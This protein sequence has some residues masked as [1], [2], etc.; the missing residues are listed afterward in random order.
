MERLP[1]IFF[2]IS[3]FILTGD[4]LGPSINGL[5]QLLRMPVGCGEQTMT[6]FA[7]DVFISNYLSATNQLSKEIED[8][9]LMYMEKG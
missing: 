2:L 6:A 9:A 4:V 5:H 3:P 1:W 7:P 8:T